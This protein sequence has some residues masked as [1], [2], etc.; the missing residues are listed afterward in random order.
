MAWRDTIK[1]HSAADLFPMMSDAELDALAE[2]IKK[3]G[4]THRLIFWSQPGG[5]LQ[6]LDGRNR[7][8]ALERIG[9]QFDVDEHAAYFFPKD[10]V[11]PYAYVVSAN[12]VRRHLTAEDKRDLI[13]KLLK[14]SPKKSDRSIAKTVEVD[15]KTVAAVRSREEIPHVD[16]RTDT[17]GRQQPATGPDVA[18]AMSAGNVAR[19][20]KSAK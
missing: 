11:D 1:V 2:D 15:N 16:K 4:L 14:A 18:N 3:N 5:K 13:A 12:I 10:T 7:L 17:K 8:E 6:L 19:A 20:M 9:I